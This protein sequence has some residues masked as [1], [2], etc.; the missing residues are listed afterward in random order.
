MV[1]GDYGLASEPK[2]ALHL[3]YSHSA[4]AVIVWSQDIDA[5]RDDVRLPYVPL[6]R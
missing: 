1:N 6:Q 3:L 4:A 5:S 2:E